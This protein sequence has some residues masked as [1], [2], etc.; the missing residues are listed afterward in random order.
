[1][2]YYII[3]KQGKR[4]L[5]PAIDRSTFAS[6]V[7]SIKKKFLYHSDYSTKRIGEVFTPDEMQGMQELV[8]EETRTMWLEN[9]G[10]GTFKKHELP[11]E[12]QFAPVNAIVCTDIDKDGNKDIILAGNEY[13]AEVSIG[14]YDA[15]YGLM[16]H[17][18][19]KGNFKSVSPVQSGLIIDG[20]VKDMKIIST[21]SGERLLLIAINNAPMKVFKMK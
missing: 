20:D 21:Q 7:P 8:C 12:A 14:Q 9:I 1:M 18:D 16:L 2:A 17:G 5:Y 3:N 11:L 4:E 10:N 13:Q 19:G 15:S 6:Q